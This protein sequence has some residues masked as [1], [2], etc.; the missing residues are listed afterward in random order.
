MVRPGAIRKLFA[1]FTSKIILVIT[2]AMVTLG[3]AQPAV[4]QASAAYAAA[5]YDIVTP[6]LIQTIL[7]TITIT[8]VVIIPSIFSAYIPSD[9]VCPIGYDFNLADIVE[10][11]KG[12]GIA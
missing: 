10:S 2:R 5:T 6:I 11:A 7:A 4:I 9:A 3:L 8:L 1:K 12:G